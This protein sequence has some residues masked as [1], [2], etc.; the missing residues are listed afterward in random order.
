MNVLKCKTCPS[1]NSNSRGFY[2]YN[3][4]PLPMSKRR[5]CSTN[6]NLDTS[7]VKRRRGTR[8]YSNQQLI[9]SKNA[10]LSSLYKK[11]STIGFWRDTS[12]MTRTETFFQLDE[13]HGTYSEFSNMYPYGVSSS[14]DA[15]IAMPLADDDDGPSV[16]LPTAE[17]WYYYFKMRHAGYQDACDFILKEPSPVKIKAICGMRGPHKWKLTKDKKTTW[18]SGARDVVMK[19]IVRQKLLQNPRIK[20]MLM[21]TSI[22]VVLVE[23]STDSYWGVGRGGSGRNMLGNILMSLRREFYEEKMEKS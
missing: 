22:D 1:K 6:E 9:D 5:S 23:N 18:D 14:S 17:H 21:D 13:T 10:V 2:F 11:S 8:H 3:T 19:R 7:N 20:D 16:R 4:Y 15:S 12:G